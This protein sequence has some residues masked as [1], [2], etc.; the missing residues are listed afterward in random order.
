M[1]A[2]KPPA[3]DEGLSQ[4]FDEAALPVAPELLGV[5][6]CVK[7]LGDRPV[8]AP[9]AA[10]LAFL[11]PA[12]APD[13][14][15]RKRLR[16]PIIGG[17]LVVSMGLGMSGVAAG[18]GTFADDLGSA[19]HSVMGQQGGA[20]AGTA[21]I[22]PQHRPSPSDLPITAPEAGP[23]QNTA[24]HSGPAGTAGSAEA[25]GPT[26]SDAV[27]A[28]ASELKP[29]PT[30]R[31]TSETDGTV[32]DREGATSEPVP[33]RSST[34]PEA[35]RPGH[36]DAGPNLVQSGPAESKPADG[37]LVRQNPAGPNPSKPE[38]TKSKP[39]KPQPAAPGTR[40]DTGR[41]TESEPGA[42]GEGHE[43][44]R[45]R[46]PLPASKEH[47]AEVDP[48]ANRRADPSVPAGPETGGGLDGDPPAAD[49]PT[50]EPE[51]D[52][53]SSEPELAQDPP[54]SPVPTAAPEPAP[55]SGEELPLRG[56]DSGVE[57][58]EVQS[59]VEAGVLDLE[60][61]VH[62]HR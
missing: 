26:G 28:G 15:R 4:L 23:V 12:D 18:P 59:A 35:G 54:P 24:G 57:P 61:A 13:R 6:G 14:G 7:S 52:L 31:S 17:T 21:P 42:P 32:D 39:K 46:A 50:P 19:V 9:G 40:Q 56:E 44:V 36:P 47:A 60:A 25:S 48:A 29:Q 11:A 3:D 51:R 62:H 55:L 16:G 33:G 37:N 10:L 5:L 1:T 22:D 2:G 43:L 34:S 38:E 49:L 53:D 30:H 58:G 8:P 20:V 45:E 41:E 27:T